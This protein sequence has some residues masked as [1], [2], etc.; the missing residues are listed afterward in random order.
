MYLDSVIKKGK[1]GDWYM[2][3]GYIVGGFQKGTEHEHLVGKFYGHVDNLT[4]GKCVMHIEG[5]KKTLLNKEAA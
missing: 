5:D 2:K 1:S 4:T 3:R